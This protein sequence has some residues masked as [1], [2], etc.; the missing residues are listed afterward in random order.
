[1]DLGGDFGGFFGSENKPGGRQ[2]TTAGER[3][4]IGWCAR[5]A[6]LLLV[7]VG[8]GGAPF[9]S[10]P[11]RAQSFLIVGLLGITCLLVLWILRRFELS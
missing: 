3:A 9:I 6:S 7:A 5:L 8:F 1:M 10:D 11:D 4:V 2:P